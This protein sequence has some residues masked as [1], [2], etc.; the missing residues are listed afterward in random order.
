M[1][2]VMIE[3]AGQTRTAWWVLAGAAAIILVVATRES[4]TLFWGDLLDD[5]E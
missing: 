4:E 2:E 5:D 1:I 3:W